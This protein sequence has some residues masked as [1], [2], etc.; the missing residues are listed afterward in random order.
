VSCRARVPC[1]DALGL[2]C[3]RQQAVDDSPL[4]AGGA[5]EVLQRDLGAGEGEGSC[6]GSETSALDVDLDAELAQHVSTHEA[7]RGLSEDPIL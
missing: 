3:Y 7:G 1:S 6:V 2:L 5:H 4:V